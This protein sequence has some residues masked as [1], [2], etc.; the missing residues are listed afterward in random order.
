MHQ[1]PTPRRA[2]R[3]YLVIA[4]LSLVALLLPVMPAR[5]I[6]GDTS[7]DG[8]AHPYVAGIWITIFCC[9]PEAAELP[10]TRVRANGILVAPNVLLTEANSFQ[11]GTRVGVSFQD[12]IGDFVDDAGDTVH[13]G[14]IF[15]HPRVKFNG[16]VDKRNNLAVIILDE[17]DPEPGIDPG[18]LG[19]VGALDASPPLLAVSV[20]P[21]E[22]D[23]SGTDT[24]PS[25]FHR[26]NT[27]ATVASL[28]SA[29]VDLALAE[30]TF[31]CFGDTGGAVVADAGIVALISGW[32]GI[33]GEGNTFVEGAA[34]GVR[35]DTA[36]ARQFLC[37]VG[38]KRFAPKVKDPNTSSNNDFVPY[39][40]VSDG[41]EGYCEPSASSARTSAQDNHGRPSADR[42]HA[43]KHRDGGHHRNGGKH[44]N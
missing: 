42:Q 22:L 38:S 6:V 25:D 19:P 39:E 4:A 13:G 15:Q 17:P 8:G 23:D 30:H 34:V 10:P 41:L 35:L 40:Q 12:P 36:A 9:P 37:D 14:Y 24:A 32:S 16:P 33:C 2:A 28:T 5:A 11:N 26:H 43:G 3:R 27:A 44:R 7:P 21:T 29:T 18:I 1:L 31:T 20:G